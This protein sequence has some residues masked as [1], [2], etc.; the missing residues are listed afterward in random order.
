VTLAD[1]VQ[2]HTDTPTLPIVY[3][4]ATLVF[5]GASACLFWMMRQAAQA[6]EER[7]VLRLAVGAGVSGL[8]A[9]A[10]LILF[11]DAIGFIGRVVAGFAI[12][13]ALVLVGNDR[14]RRSR[15]YR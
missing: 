11:A 5:C 15:R 13:A 1:V 3:A 4:I 14:A 12:A 8:L 10:A 2:V 9:A 7:F 6:Y